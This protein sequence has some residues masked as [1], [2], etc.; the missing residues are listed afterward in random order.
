VTGLLQHFKREA[1]GFRSRFGPRVLWIH[2]AIVAVF[3]VALPWMRGID[4]LDP[5]MLAAYACLGILFAAPAAAQACAA[6]PPISFKAAISL[7][8]VA[9]A[10]GETMAGTTLSA[11]LLTVYFTTPHVLFALDLEALGKAGV[12]GIAASTALATL[13]A[14]VTLTFS[15]TVARIAMR[16]IFLGLLWLFFSYSRW[17][18]DVAGRASIVSLGITAIT[19]IALARRQFPEPR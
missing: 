9:V 12:L 3:G 4:F 11:A 10:Y 1:T 15:A 8:A 13:A 7:I 18:P 2:I 19:L 5:V 17:L 6:E 14:W 16:V